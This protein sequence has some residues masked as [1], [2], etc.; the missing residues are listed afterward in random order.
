MLSAR[1][2]RT[3]AAELGIR[4]TKQWGQNF[5]IDANTVERIVRLAEVGEDAVVVEIG[6]GLGS[7]TLALLPR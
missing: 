4:P 1:D 2:I 3:L 5:V 6:P 7:L